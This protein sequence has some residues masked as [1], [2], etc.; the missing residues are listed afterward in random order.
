MKFKLPPASRA[1][2]PGGISFLGTKD[3][4]YLP[5]YETKV[6]KLGNLYKCPQ[7]HSRDNDV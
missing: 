2:W 6:T 3:T 7:L 5:W 4:E 1:Y